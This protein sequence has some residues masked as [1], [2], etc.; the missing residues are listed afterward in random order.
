MTTQTENIPIPEPTESFEHYSIRALGSLMN[1]GMEPDEKNQLVRYTW[2]QHR[3]L[4][5]EQAL[6]QRTFDKDKYRY[7]PDVVVFAE[8][9]TVDKQGKPRKYGLKEL[10]QIV[11]DCNARVNDRGVFA[12]IS[13]GHTSNPGDAVKRDPQILGWAGPYRLGVSGRKNPVWSILADEYHIKEASPILDRKPRRS[14][15]LWTF[16]NGQEM[17]FD[18]IAA[19]GAEAPRLPLPMRYS[20]VNLNGA[21]VEK[22]TYDATVDMYMSKTH[23]EAKKVAD[24]RFDDAEPSSEPSDKRV[25]ASRAEEVRAHL[26]DK[27]HPVNTS[28]KVVSSGKYGKHFDNPESSGLSPKDHLK[29]VGLHHSSAEM[30]KFRKNKEAEDFHRKQASKHAAEYAKS[31]SPPDIDISKLSLASNSTPEQYDACGGAP[32][33]GVGGGSPSS[34]GSSGGSSFAYPGSGSTF[35]K[36]H[37]GGKA[38]KTKYA[39]TP[40]SGSPNLSPSTGASSMDNPSDLAKQVVAFLVQTPE[41][42]WVREHMSEDMNQPAP[43]N[44]SLDE[45]A[46]APPGEPGAGDATPPAPVPGATQPAPQQED[47]SD[48]IDKVGG[49]EPPAETEPDGDESGPSANEPPPKKP[50]DKEKFSMANANDQA[51]VEKYAA[52]QASHDSL[53]QEHTRTCARLEVLEKSRSDAQ[54]TM[55]LRELAGKY[56]IDADAEAEKFL[57]SK[58]ASASDSEFDTFCNFVE[59]YAAQKVVNH[60][61]PSG[62]APTSE[63]PNGEQT[64]KYQAALRSEL[65]KV[66]GEIVASGKPSNYA[67]ELAIAKQRLG[68]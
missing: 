17:H 4:T 12:A 8:H 63:D 54:R 67:E 47:L 37:G 22:Y 16:R 25:V 7:V 13:D 32:G 52:L 42:Q 65:L 43:G 50:E 56:Q 26:A 20:T 44:E 14:V 45:L 9:E 39:E 18:P 36:S 1:S 61:L 68:K 34:F 53:M 28:K 51:T 27:S 57:Y 19:I 33:G 3:G 23:Q 24:K 5:E 15:E 11:K 38:K 40:T 60:S 59:K 10:A 31:I 30:H 55:K 41:F 6:A 49:G 48:V 21:E 58:G 62:D 46:A 2:N 35:V 64:E 29:M 66:H